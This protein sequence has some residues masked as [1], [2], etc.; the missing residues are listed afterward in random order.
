[1][2]IDPNAP[3]RLVLDSQRGVVR[4]RPASMMQFNAGS[5]T[6]AGVAE[7]NAV[8]WHVGALQGEGVSIAVIDIFNDTSKEIDAL[9]SS[10]DWPPDARLSTVKIGGGS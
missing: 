3:I 1:M 2:P 4:V 5:V 7:G 10:G 6:S 8:L 9:Q